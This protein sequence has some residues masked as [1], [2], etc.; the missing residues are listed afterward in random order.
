[1][2]AEYLGEADCVLR[3]QEV[4]LLYRDSKGRSY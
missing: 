3:P 4:R 2:V 1:M